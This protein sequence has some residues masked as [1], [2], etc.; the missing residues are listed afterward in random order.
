LPYLVCGRSE[1][2]QTAHFVEKLFNGK[3]SAKI[4]NIVLIRGLLA[5]LIRD[6]AISRDDVLANSSLS[7][8][9]RVFQQNPP[10]LWKNT[11]L[12]AQKVWF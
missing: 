5:N 10:I 12:L 7:A 8:E 2:P 1:D 9:Y 4:W 11:V 6:M 3:I